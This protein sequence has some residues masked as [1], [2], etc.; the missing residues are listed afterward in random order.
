[1]KITKQ[2]KICKLFIL[3]IMLGI[4]IGNLNAEMLIKT[5]MEPAQEN[6]L[7]GT[8]IK[9]MLILTNTSDDCYTVFYDKFDALQIDFPSFTIN[10]K[11]GNKILNPNIENLDGFVPFVSL[12]AKKSKV[13]PLYINNYWSINQPGAC[14]LSSVI[15]LRVIRFEDDKEIG[16]LCTT[17][18]LVFSLINGTTNEIN[19]CL[20]NYTVGFDSKNFWE[21]RRS[22]KQA[23]ALAA[24]KSPIAIDYL[25]RG[26]KSKKIKVS[27]W[28]SKGL[29][30]IN[31][32][33]ADEALVWGLTNGTDIAKYYIMKFMQSNNRNIGKALPVIKKLASSPKDTVSRTALFYLADVNETNRVDAINSLLN[34][35]EI[36]ENVREK[37]KDVVRKENANK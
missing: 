35:P 1:M 31:G 29:A 34:D 15:N 37:I 2:N 33:E 3:C 22:D 6:Y 9:V 25:K 12:K 21:V 27:Y 16:T 32:Q 18:K 11:L 23:E 14:Q 5:K 30:E 26:L 28:S 20:D 24:L 19:D 7:L 8:P 4:Y 13:I 10:S 36:S 17:N